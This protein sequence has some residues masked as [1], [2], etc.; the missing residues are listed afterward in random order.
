MGELGE[1]KSTLVQEEEE[2]G[3]RESTFVAKAL[4]ASDSMDPKSILQSPECESFVSEVVV[5]AKKVVG[6]GD[7]TILD[8]FCSD[9]EREVVSSTVKSKMNDMV[10]DV[11]F[12]DPEA[13]REAYEMT[14]IGQV[15]FVTQALSNRDSCETEV[16]NE[17]ANWHQL[18]D[19]SGERSSFW[20]IAASIAISV[21]PSVI[22]WFT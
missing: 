3:L 18:E 5:K 15:E 8:L 22:S 14:K 20:F 19:E 21:V 13:C 10:K 12:G 7:E 6:F 9:S 2:T 16:K 1:I 4:E 17:L 11:L